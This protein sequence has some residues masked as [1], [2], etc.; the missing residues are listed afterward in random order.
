MK[1]AIF[2]LDGT[3]VDSLADLAEASNFALRKLGFPT[4]PTE[5]FKLFVGNGVYKQLERC[6]PQAQRGPET[7]AKVYE[8]YSEYY[9]RHSEDNTRP[10]PGMTETIAKIR[11]GGVSTAVLTNKP[12]RLAAPMVASLFPGLFD[13][14]LGQREGVP[15]KPDPAAVEEIIAHFGV[16]KSDCCYIGDSNVDMKTG[17]AAGLFTIGVTWGFRTKEELES[18]G[19]NIILHK[20]EDL[21]SILVDKG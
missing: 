19:A 16:R 9:A 6:L 2:D 18:A 14:A 10:F 3:L 13:L 17:Q 12:H 4:H 20:V 7:L 21:A 15:I 1:L 8:I 5:A 11:A